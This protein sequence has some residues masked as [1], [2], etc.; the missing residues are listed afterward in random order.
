MERVQTWY[1]Q[2][3]KIWWF[4]VV[5]FTILPCALI[6]A[7]LGTYIIHKEAQYRNSLQAYGYLSNYHVWSGIFRKRQNSGK[8]QGTHYS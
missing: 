1:R 4:K 6:C 8:R 3:I 2:K 5:C 7:A